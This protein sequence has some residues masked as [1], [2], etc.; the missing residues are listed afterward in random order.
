MIVAASHVFGKDCAGR[1]SP[2]GRRLAV[3]SCWRCAGRCEAIVCSK[4]SHVPAWL[5]CHRARRSSGGSL[6]MLRYLQAQLDSRYLQSQLD[7]WHSHQNACRSAKHT[8]NSGFHPKVGVAG[9]CACNFSRSQH[10]LVWTFSMTGLQLCWPVGEAGLSI[11]V[12]HSLP[13]SE[14]KDIY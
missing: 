8:L 1:M 14:C 3:L 4:F 10:S 6:E 9:P 5:I 11:L 13:M 7:S 2:A 12:T